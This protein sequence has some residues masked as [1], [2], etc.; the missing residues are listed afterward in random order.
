[1]CLAYTLLTWLYS[2][3]CFNFPYGEHSFQVGINLRGVDLTR[4][5]IRTKASMQEFHCYYCHYRHDQ[6]NTYLYCGR[7]SSQG[8]VDCFPCVEEGRL[9]YIRDHQG[10]FRC[11]NIQGIADAVGRGCLDGGVG[12]QRILPTSFTGERR[13]MY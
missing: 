4:T 2:T 3:H 11:E 5:A 13:Y 10:D 9:T 8:Q 12:K 6:F 1:M 7:L